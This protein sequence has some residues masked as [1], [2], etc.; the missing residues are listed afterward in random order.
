MKRLL[1]LPLLLVL[2]SCALWAPKAEDT[3]AL[4]LATQK[5]DEAKVKTFQA[6]DDRLK[7]FRDELLKRA[8]GEIEQGRLDDIHKLQIGTEKNVVNPDGTSTT[9]YVP[10]VLDPAKVDAINANAKKMTDDAIKHIMDGWD[11]SH[12]IQVEKDFNDVYQSLMLYWMTRLNQDQQK[13]ALAD[14][15]KGMV[16][17]PKK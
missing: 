10:G 15:L 13:Q 14:Q 16:S 7:I 8:L 1:L 17:T 5:L 12:D 6:H 2:A 4:M 11:A 9:T 3:T